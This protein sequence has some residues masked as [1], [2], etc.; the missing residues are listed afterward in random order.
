MWA[1][2]RDL[3][4]DV[5]YATRVPMAM[6]EIEAGLPES[7]IPTAYT[8]FARH[9][10]GNVIADFE[11]VV[12]YA[13]GNEVKRRFPRR[14]GQPNLLILAPDPLLPR[15]G[16]VAPRCQVYADLFNLPT[17]QAQRFLEALDH[18]LFRDVA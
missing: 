3:N 1:A 8:A 6:T 15:Y 4:A 5:V 16:R 9:Q 13:D 12:A 7:A 11:Q 14:R 10:G 18:Q 17:W 2:M